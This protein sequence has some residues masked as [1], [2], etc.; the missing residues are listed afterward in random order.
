M[1]KNYCKTAANW[2]AKKIQKTESK[3][4]R[5]LELFEERLSSQ[6]NYLTSINGTL[7]ISTLYSSSKL[8]DEIAFYSGL[9]ANIPSGYEMRIFF[10]NIFVY[11]SYGELVA[12]F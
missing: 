11:N 5:G 12:N 4:I 1:T 3:P 2:W 7:A 10:N 9:T 6:I 8:L